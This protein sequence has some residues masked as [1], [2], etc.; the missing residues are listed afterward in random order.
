MPVRSINILW[1]YL[2]DVSPW[3]GCYGDNTVCTPNIDRLAREGHCFEQCFAP[4][5][6]CSPARTAVI[7]G[8]MPT[9]LGLHHHRSS[10]TAWDPHPLPPD[11]PTLPE[12][13]RAVGYHTFNAGKDDYNFQYDR[14]LLYPGPYSSHFHWKEGPSVELNSLPSSQPF[15]GQIQLPGGKAARDPGVAGLMPPLGEIALPPYYPDQPLFREEIAAHYA[16][17]READRQVGVILDTLAKVGLLERTAVFL[18]SDHGMEGLRHKQFCYD[19]GLHVPLILRLP[20]G[21][22]PQRRSDL[23]STVDITATTLALAEQPVPAWFEGRS[24]L[25]HP[26]RSHLVSARDRC[27]FTLDRIRSVRTGRYRY[28]RNYHPERPWLQPQYRSNWPIFRTWLEQAEAGVLP[29]EQAAFA[30]SIRPAEELYDVQ[31]DPH[32]MRNLARD[33]AFGRILEE[34]RA[35]LERWIVETHDQGELGFG[36][37]DL[38]ATLLRWREQCVDPAYDP[39]RARHAGLIA[40]HP[41]QR[42]WLNSANPDAR[43]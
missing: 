21:S 10:R 37:G 3:L 41:E 11:R 19:G 25:G 6:V 29:P 2:E 34:H 15:F 20:G 26:K 7:T 31:T 8:Q 18:F 17:L 36:E 30:S 28:I 12:F 27:D 23:V 9:S 14:E 33:P 39:V 13:L 22:A 24:L 35:L 5:P 42:P 40:R 16:C 32:A 38:L 43:K 4:S 1:I